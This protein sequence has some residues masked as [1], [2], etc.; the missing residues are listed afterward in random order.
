MPSI[1]PT[2][3]ATLRRRYSQA[4]N[5][6]FLA[7][8]KDARISLD[9]RDGLGLRTNEPA[10][11]GSF[12]FPTSA[13]KIEAFQRWLR[14]EIDR[15]VLEVVLRNQQEILLHREWQNPFIRSA[16]IRGVTDAETQ[17]K[18]ANRLV[19][20]LDV[21][22]GLES[23]V[24]LDT[25]ELMFTR[26]FEGLRGISESMSGQ[27][28]EILSQGLI[29]G[30]GPKQIAKRITDQIRKISRT[31]ALVL[32]RTEVIRTYAE[33]TLN[34]FEQNGIEGVTADVEFHTAGDGR[35]CQRCL[36][37]EG[38]LFTI[39]ESRGIIPLH[40]RCRCAWLGANI[41]E[42]QSDVKARAT[43]RRRARARRRELV[44]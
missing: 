36:F 35:V 5:R 39:Q 44:A 18:R 10:P 9:D 1:D 24:H 4:M 34:T 15:G 2:H 17:L 23:G 14:R 8:A 29:D 20:P 21:S 30:I 33:S 6:R 37:L 16:Y 31:R 41:G 11:V 38:K 22:I 7:L 32:A 27:L 3:T 28:S 19:A 40:P 12:D 26:V 13:G 42:S 43:R 25:L